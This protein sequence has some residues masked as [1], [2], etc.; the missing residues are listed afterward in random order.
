MRTGVEVQLASE[1]R[2]RLVAERNTPQKHV[3]RAQIVLLSADGVGTME[4]MRRADQSEPTVWRW[5]G[6]FAEAGVAGLLG[7]KTRPP[8]KKPLAAAVVQQV[9]TTTT[10]ETPPEATAAYP[11]HEGSSAAL[12]GQQSERLEYGEIDTHAH[13]LRPGG[14]QRAEQ[15][16]VHALDRDLT[17]PAGPNDLRQPACVVLVRLVQLQ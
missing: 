2:A 14:K 10:T 8:G 13:Q 3:W 16:A 4:I 12:A 17:I 11:L 5:Q 9:V 7:D 15:L 1:D 6:R